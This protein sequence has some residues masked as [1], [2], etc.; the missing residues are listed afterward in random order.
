MV[1]NLEAT[2]DDLYAL[3]SEQKAEIVNGE[4]V[5][6]SPSGAAPSYA[7]A[8]IF[9]SLREYARRTKSGLAVGDNAAFIVDNLS[10]RK[11]FSPN[12]AFYVGEWT[13]MKFFRGAPMFA[14]EVRGERDY[15]PAVEE[16]I[17]KKR[18]DYLNAGTQAV[19]DVNLLSDDVVK[20]YS[21]YYEHDVP[22][23]FRRGDTAHA[24]PGVR[25]WS[26]PVDDL[27]VDRIES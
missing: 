3:P 23:I 27:F 5:L 19:W 13:G 25:G 18:Y 17:A 24:E 1:A 2:I 9:A 10:N 21:I 4:I 22:S 14:G 16:M 11:S 15:G 20:L 7:A 26:M 6:M 8:E 12:A